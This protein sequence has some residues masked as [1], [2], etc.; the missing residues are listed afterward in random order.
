M[1]A[2]LVITRG[3]TAG[4]VNFVRKRGLAAAHTDVTLSG[5]SWDNYRTEFD[6]SNALNESGTLRGRVVTAYQSKNG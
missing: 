3:G 6:A 2:S 5:G 4:G 1:K